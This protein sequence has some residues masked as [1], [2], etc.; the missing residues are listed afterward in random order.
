MDGIHKFLKECIFSKPIEEQRKFIKIIYGD[1]IQIV[2]CRSMNDCTNGIYKT[3][4]LSKPHI[5]LL[6]GELIGKYGRM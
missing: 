3:D 2:T 4:E 5:D 1:D 6:L